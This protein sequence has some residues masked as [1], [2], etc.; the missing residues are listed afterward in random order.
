MFDCWVSV[1]RRE[2]QPVKG[3]VSSLLEKVR[4]GTRKQLI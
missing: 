4:V 3:V 1:G 2:D